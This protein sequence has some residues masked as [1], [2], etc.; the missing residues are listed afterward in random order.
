MSRD[1]QTNCCLSRKISSHLPGAAGA[2]VGDGLR[3]RLRVRRK[4]AH[5]DDLADR[6]PIDPATSSGFVTRTTR[7]RHWT[8]RDSLVL[9]LGLVVA[10]AAAVKRRAA[11]RA[12]QAE[13]FVVLAAHDFVLFIL[14]SPRTAP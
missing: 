6:V 8:T 9:R 14:H 4:A 5:A 12:N 13:A 2:L 11:G 10:E 7:R 3:R 1:V